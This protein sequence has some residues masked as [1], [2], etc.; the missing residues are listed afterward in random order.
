MPLP[1]IQLVG[2]LT[3]DPELRTTSGGKFVTNLRL[4]CNDRKKN[5][6]GEWVDGD[7]LFIDVVCWR[8]AEAINA[9]LVKG[10]KVVVLGTLRANDYEKDGV[11]VKAYRVNADDVS[12]LVLGKSPAVMPPITNAP[13][14][15]PWATPSSGF[16]TGDVPF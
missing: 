11:K 9:T 2:N 10:S 8:N 13:K 6:A 3:A 15:D 4:A 7:S 5:E 1:T 14:S 12:Q 16:D